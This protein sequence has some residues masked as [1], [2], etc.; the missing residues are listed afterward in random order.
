MEQNH[1]KMNI[2][3][4]DLEWLY[5]PDVLY[6]EYDT[7]K[8]YLQMFVPYR[9]HWKENEKFPLVVFIPGSAWYR[10]EMY[11]SIPSYSKLAERGIVTAVVQHR[12]STIAP[13]PAQVHDI[14]YA[15]GFLMEKAEELHIDINNIYIAGNSSGGHLALMTSLMKAHGIIN[16]AYEIKGVIAESA[17]SDLILCAAEGI[18]DWMPEDFRPTRDLL[19]VK[20][21]DE[22]L[23]L[24]KQASCEM[25][26]TRDVTIPRVLLIHGTDDCQVNIQHSR[27][28]FEQ[29]RKVDKD[30]LFYE[31]EGSD[32]GGSE[33]W[34]KE[35]VDIIE[36]FVQR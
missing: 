33:F 6:K 26:I 17:P 8:R 12:E 25:Y 15:I 27:Q 18:P 2:S 23:E 35:V 31:L 19:G 5:V 28:L 10:Q 21:I 14:N 9:H 3:C 1:F 30:V 13:F 4:E 16:G 22:N 34:S 29:L 20:Q 11:N 7:C 24:A 32:H 36:S